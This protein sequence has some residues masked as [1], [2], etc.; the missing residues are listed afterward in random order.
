MKIISDTRSETN[1]FDRISSNLGNKYCIK[2]QDNSNDNDKQDTY[3]D[4]DTFLDLV[5][6]HLYDAN[7]PNDVIDEFRQF[8][9]SEGYDSVSLELDITKKHENNGNISNDINNMECIV[10]VISDLNKI[11]GIYLYMFMFVYVL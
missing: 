8:M 11:R 9:I 5:H 4:M 6:Q 3:K 1:R 7:V 2:N 10:V